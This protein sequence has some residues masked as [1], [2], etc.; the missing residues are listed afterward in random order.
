[1]YTA[2]LFGFA[3]S[4]LFIIGAGCAST[5]SSAS[6]G[7]TKSGQYHRGQKVVKRAAFTPVDNPTATAGRGEPD[8]EDVFRPA[9]WIYLDNTGGTFVERDGFPQVQ[10]MTEKGVSA[11]PTFRVEA[12]DSLLG[13]PTGFACT[14]DTVEAD[15]GSR[16]AYAIR[17]EKGSFVA[18]RSYSLLRPGSNFTIRNRNSNDVVSEISPLAPGTYLIAAKVENVETGQAGLAITHFTVGEDH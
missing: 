14:L 15:D 2:R 8:L 12:L 3:V 6:T 9:A 11:T 10:W 16:I 1:M 13:N 5:D 7:H 17:A 18:G 4:G